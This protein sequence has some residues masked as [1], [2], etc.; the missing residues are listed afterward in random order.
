M[1]NYIDLDDFNIMQIFL[2]L[3]FLHP[4]LEMEI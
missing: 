1:N 4:Q 3:F 2:G